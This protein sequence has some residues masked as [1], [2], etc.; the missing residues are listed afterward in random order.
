VSWAPLWLSLQVAAAA[1]VLAGLAGVAVAALLARPR[2]WGRD[3]LD[4]ICS[5]PMVMPPTVLGYYVLVA[6]GKHGTIGRFFEAATGTQIVFTK[7][8]AI[9][10]AAIGSFPLVARSARA[11]LEGVDPRV[12]GVARTLARP[13]RVWFSVTLPLAAPGVIAG[14]T[15]GLARALGDFGLTLMVAGDIPGETQTASLAI[16]DAIQANADRQA[17]AMILV[18]S[19]ISIG[20]LWGINKLVRRRA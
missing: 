12:V 9:I 5:A 17:L 16:Y 20:A 18:L 8:G 15:L 14:L 10:A 6:L 13:V 19:A 1:T 3:L 2:F 7:T 11:A 4:A